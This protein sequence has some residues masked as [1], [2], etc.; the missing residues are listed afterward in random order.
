[1][2]KFGFPVDNFNPSNSSPA[3]FYITVEASAYHQEAQGVL[4]ARAIWSRQEPDLR[5]TGIAL[6]KT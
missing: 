5:C 4:I 1:M 2:F 3:V 6:T